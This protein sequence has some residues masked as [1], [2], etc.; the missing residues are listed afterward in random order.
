MTRKDKSLTDEDHKLWTFIT[1]K[2]RP[3]AAEKQAVVKNS[4]IPAS[5]AL[6]RKPVPVIPAVSGSI[7]FSPDLLSPGLLSPAL[8][9]PGLPSPFSFPKNPAGA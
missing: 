4:P 9:A 7:P 8:P 2:I 1:R 5:P 3:L 6:C